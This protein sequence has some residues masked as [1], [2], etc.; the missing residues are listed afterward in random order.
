MAR[1]ATSSRPRS[2]ASLF[3]GRAR[4]TATAQAAAGPYLF[5][6]AA[7]Y[8][9]GR[10]TRLGTRIG[11]SYLDETVTTDLGG[12]LVADLAA[13]FQQP[14]NPCSDRNIRC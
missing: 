9:D 3:T 12:E 7:G 14:A 5:L 1:S 2:V 4:E 10:S 13:P 8:A 6:Y 11:A